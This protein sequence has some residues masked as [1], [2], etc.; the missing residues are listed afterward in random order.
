MPLNQRPGKQRDL[1][2]IWTEYCQSFDEIISEERELLTQEGTRILMYRYRPRKP[3]II[4]FQAQQSCCL[5][6][7]LDLW[8]TLALARAKLLFK[9]GQ[10]CV[11]KIVE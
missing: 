7:I 5:S 11:Y 2:R 8:S 4:V 10:V 3:Y 6:H 1:L 9:N